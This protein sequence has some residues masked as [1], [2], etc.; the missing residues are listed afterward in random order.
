MQF[1]GKRL[2][3]VRMGL[4]Y[5]LGEIHNQIATCPAPAEYEDE[6]EALEQEKADI[7]KL[8]QE[9]DRKHPEVCKQLGLKD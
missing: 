1:T 6:I 3:L 8:I 7:A 9:I 5:A 4:S 2:Q